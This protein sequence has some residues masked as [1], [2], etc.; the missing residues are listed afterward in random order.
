M[1]LVPASLWMA[2]WF[3]IR[4][5]VFAK[6]LV[7]L[8]FLFFPA[9]HCAADEITLKTGK[10]L[11]GRITREDVSMVEIETD[12]GT[13]A[14]P[15]AK[16]SRARRDAATRIP[17]NALKKRLAAGETKAVLAE[18]DRLRSD[19]PGLTEEVRVRF[20]AL[21][22]EARGMSANAA[23]GAQLAADTALAS[24]AEAVFRAKGWPGAMARLES[25]IKPGSPFP[26]SRLMRLNMNAFD[27]NG[28]IPIKEFTAFLGEYPELALPGLAAKMY[29]Q[30]YVELFK[31]RNSDKIDVRV[32]LGV[33]GFIRGIKTGPMIDEPQNVRTA[34]ALSTGKPPVGRAEAM[35]SAD[36]WRASWP[37]SMLAP[38][39]Q[40][41]AAGGHTPKVAAAAMLTILGEATLAPELVPI[42]ESFAKLSRDKLAAAAPTPEMTAECAD[43]CYACA[44]PMGLELP[45]CLD[46]GDFGAASVL[47]D[48]MT[49]FGEWTGLTPGAPPAL[50][51]RGRRDPAEWVAA[52]AEPGSTRLLRAGLFVG[53][54]KAAQA[55][56]LELYC[57]VRANFEGRGAALPK[58][59]L[60][61]KLEASKEALLVKLRLEGDPALLANAADYFEKLVGPM[62]GAAV[63][64]A[65]RDLLR[66]TAKNETNSKAMLAEAMTVVRN[67]PA[68]DVTSETV[69]SAAE[70]MLGKVKLLAKAVPSD[71][72]FAEGMGKVLAQA[73]K[74]PGNGL[75]L[76]AE[77][78]ERLRQAAL[79]RQLKDENAASLAEQALRREEAEAAERRAKA[80]RMDQARRD[81]S[82]IIPNM[83]DGYFATQ[84]KHDSGARFYCN[85]CNV[86][87]FSNVKTYMIKADSLLVTEQG[88]ASMK[89]LV[90][91]NSSAGM[92]IE[93]WCIVTLGFDE[94]SAGWCIKD[95]SKEF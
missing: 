87:A 71:S 94:E 68:G 20:A 81:A 67:F 95:I 55:A 18:L 6:T 10:T 35:P 84:K 56:D 75:R 42:V 52:Q 93:F 48:R 47:V 33:M 34:L 19:L 77:R 32:P 45:G 22:A 13:V 7:F 8:P 70:I 46:R 51:G 74:A 31:S 82:R 65:Y 26:K 41:V 4:L 2:R 54:V 37:A 63:P 72:V 21:E 61:R 39:L 85:N 58:D 78:D 64:A 66:E 86:Y 49:V 36:E 30:C 73:E 90:D 24:E 5:T 80:Q 25:G 92:A 40:G 50:S 23:T 29:G 28:G 89:V 44:Y 16:I 9:V 69:R 62:I 76:V 12:A 59:S 91:G 79:A 57:M 27:S 11:T 83:V 60:T 88:T 14:F 38:A 3:P 1:S 43:F 53:G 15:L 17:I